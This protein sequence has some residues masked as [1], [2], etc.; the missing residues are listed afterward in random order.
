MARLAA[1]AIGV[2][3]NGGSFLP[4]PTLRG[5][6]ALAVGTGLLAVVALA[7]PLMLR[8]RGRAALVTAALVTASAEI[9]IVL[10]VLSVLRALTA[11]GILLAELLLAAA[12]TVA[13]KA[14]G[15]P[16]PLESWR[17][18]DLSTMLGCVRAHR[19]VAA[20]AALACAA[21]AVQLVQA[22]V[23]APNT[24]DSMTYHLSRIAYWLQ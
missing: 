16:R 19:A 2:A 12:A 23:I 6:V 11:P 20:A 7:V 9:V 1:S 17:L 18:P 21:L 4:L 8:I 22:L 10:S 13:W 5:L 14:V 3:S 24:L 15:R